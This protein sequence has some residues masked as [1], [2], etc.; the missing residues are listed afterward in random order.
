VAGANTAA[1]P[2]ATIGGGFNNVAS[3]YYAAVG[4]GYYNSST[5]TAATVPGGW[6]N[7]AAGNYSFAAGFAANAANQGAF[8]WADSQSGAFSSTANNQFCIRAQ[9][10]VQLDP[11]TTIAFGSTPREMLQ[12][13]RDPTSTYIYGLGVQTATFYMRTGTNGGFA[14]Y[15]GGTYIDQQNNPGGGK[16]LMSLSTSGLV[17]NGTFISSSDRN[18]KQNF[19]P[20][21][22]QTVLAKVARLPEQTWSYKEDP[23]TK[24]LGPMAQDFYAA[25]GTGADDRHIAVVDEGGVALAAIQGLN[26]QVQAREIVIEEQAGEIADLQTRL[27]KL[28]KFVNDK[29]GGAK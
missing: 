28:E 25:F 19:A 6:D 10:G 14:W 2:A 21:D 3:G 18:A 9:G 24:H 12:L 4:G 20:V 15:E 27:E 13:Y 7:A 17:V 11:T 26:Q 1:G 5:G 22:C 23:A 29:L 16:T 8:V